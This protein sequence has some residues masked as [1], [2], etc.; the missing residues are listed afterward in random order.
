MEEYMEQSKLKLENEITRLELRLKELELKQKEFEEKSRKKLNPIIVGIIAACLGLLGNIFVT[1]LEG[2]NAL[3]LESAKLQS[4]LILEAIKTGN[5]NLAEN[6]LEFLLEAGLIEDEDGKIEGFLSK[7]E[8]EIP[9]LPSSPGGALMPIYHR[10]EE[11]ER[12]ENIAALYGVTVEAIAE[13]NGMRPPYPVYAGQVL[14]IPP[15]E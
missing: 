6:N 2:E 9:F 12:L 15:A 8:K 14:L 4:S 10:V 5:Q 11:G 1:Y 13:A 7:E 3:E